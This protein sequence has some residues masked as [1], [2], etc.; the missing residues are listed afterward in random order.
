MGNIKILTIVASLPFIFST[1]VYADQAGTNYAGI[2][3]AMTSYDEVG[4][5][6][7]NPSVLV[8][9][10]GHYIT[11]TLAMEARLGM[12]MFLALTSKLIV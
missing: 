11:D 8:G 9:R 12:G 1:P 10:I 4:Y 5:S 6:T 3:Y 2:Q 7:A